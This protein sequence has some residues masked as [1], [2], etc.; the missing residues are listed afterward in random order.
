MIKQTS[1]ER[2][3]L[4]SFDFYVLN[5]ETFKSFT[6]FSHLVSYSVIIC[7]LKQSRRKTFYSFVAFIS[8]TV[9]CD[10]SSSRFFLHPQWS[11]SPLSVCFQCDC[12]CVFNGGGF[13]YILMVIGGLEWS[14]CS[15][16]L[17]P[18]QGSGAGL[19]IDNGRS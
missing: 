13:S 4:K 11:P 12:V 2:I 19:Q 8:C 14:F 1:S 18:L 10:E 6:F 9:R 3:S 16:T 5:A 17:G 15:E 7:V